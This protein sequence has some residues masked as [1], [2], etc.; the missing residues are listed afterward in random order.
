MV[1]AVLAV[2]VTTKKK[3]LSY[4]KALTPLPDF[5]ARLET[6]IFLSMNGVWQELNATKHPRRHS[7]TKSMFGNCKQRASGTVN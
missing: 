4:P 7:E 6:P 2:V 5:Q 1:L 3:K